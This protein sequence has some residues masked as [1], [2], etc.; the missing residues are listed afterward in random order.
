MPKRALPCSACINSI[1]PGSKVQIS[2]MA[3]KNA[4]LS[5]SVVVLS[6]SAQPAK[7]VCL[8]CAAVISPFW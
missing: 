6:F 4:L 8:S 7:R 1:A 3:C 2:A 5:S